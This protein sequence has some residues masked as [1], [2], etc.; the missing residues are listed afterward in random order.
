MELL[1][2][3]L[4]IYSATSSILESWGCQTKVSHSPVGREPK[5]HRDGTRTRASAGAGV[6]CRCTRWRGDQTRLKR[7]PTQGDHRVSSPVSLSPEPHQP[8]HGLHSRL[9]PGMLALDNMLYLAKV[10]QDT[11]IR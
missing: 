1:K 2:Y 9:R 11:Y 3:L 6:V 10:H 7:A 5:P 4:G 8:P